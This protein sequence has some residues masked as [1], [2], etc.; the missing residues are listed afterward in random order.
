MKGV[1]KM[2]IGINSTYN[3]YTAH[4]LISNINSDISTQDIHKQ[5]SKKKGST[6]IPFGRLMDIIN[7]TEGESLGL[8]TGY[9]VTAS[10]FKAESFSSCNPVM[11]VRGINNGDHF[12]IEIDI[13]NID[14]RN[15]TQIE[16]FALEGYFR[17]NGKHSDIM[18]AMTVASLILG[19]GPSNNKFVNADF[20]NTRHD[21][22]TPLQAALEN[23]EKQEQL[24]STQLWFKSMSGTLLNH[25]TQKQI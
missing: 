5:A 22:I 4:Q 11:L 1:K 15:A 24:F 19:L 16:M 3:S 10:V 21:F 7:K 13:R 18:R 17:A 12:E 14:P 9:S 23:L 2:S 8:L 20:F 6:S 25:F